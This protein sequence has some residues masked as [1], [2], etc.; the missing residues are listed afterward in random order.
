MKFQHEN[1]SEININLIIV[2]RLVQILIIT[3]FTTL[4]ILFVYTNSFIE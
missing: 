4:F 1:Y 2:N 3:F